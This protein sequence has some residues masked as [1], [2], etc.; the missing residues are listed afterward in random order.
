MKKILNKLTGW[1]PWNKQPTIPNWTPKAGDGIIDNEGEPAVIRGVTTRGKVTGSTLDP[2]EIV[3]VEVMYFGDVDTTSLKV[4]EYRH[5]TFDEFTNRPTGYG[6][7][8]WLF[9]IIFYLFLFVN[10]VVSN[11]PPFTLLGVLSIVA[12]LLLHLLFKYMTW[13]NYVRK[14]V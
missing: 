9:F 3:G 10:I 13:R 14:T 7:T 2:N 1:L 12:G 5:E 8:H 11:I 6:K 4:G